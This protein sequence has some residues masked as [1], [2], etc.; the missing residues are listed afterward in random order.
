MDPGTVPRSLSPLTTMLLPRLGR[1]RRWQ[2]RQ[3]LDEG[4]RRLQILHQLVVSSHQIARLSF[5][6]GHVETVVDRLLG[7]HANVNGPWEKRDGRVQE[8]GSL[9]NFSEE[10]GRIAWLDAPCPFG[11]GESVG[12]FGGEKVGSQQF[13][14]RIVEIVAKA[15]GLVG[16]EFAD[17]PFET[18]GGVDDVFHRLL[19]IWRIIS[20]PMFCT[21]K[22]LRFS[23]RIRS[24]R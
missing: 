10:Q 11:D 23:S 13:V 17:H 1:W 3:A 5:R 18:D 16:V 9:E 6:Q 22:S 21:P 20:T 24:I 7:L 19:R 15:D 14:D 4:E 12:D 8:R 2:R